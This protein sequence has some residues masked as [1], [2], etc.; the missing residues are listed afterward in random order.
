MGEGKFE[1]SSGIPALDD[2]L[3][4]L[5]KGD[6]VVWETD[7]LADY[8]H[9]L[10]PFCRN[11]VAEGKPLV[12]FRFAQH[13]H[14]LPADVSAEVVELSP[15][16]GFEQ[17]V[18]SILTEIEKHGP[19]AC[20]VFDCLS[21]LSVDWYSDRMLG[22][23]FM[24]TCPYL[25]D[26]DTLTY[27]LLRKSQHMPF[28]V[29]AIHN[30]AQVVVEVY[31]SEG[32]RY[33]LPIKVLERYSPTMYTLHSCADDAF[34]PVTKSVITAQILS[35]VPQTWLDF[36]IDR[37]DI[38]TETF[39]EAQAMNA[40]VY[41]N[42]RI[43]GRVDSLRQQLIRMI[44]TREQS[45][46]GLCDRYLDVP[47]LIDIGKRM[48]GTGLIGGKSVGMILARA[49]LRHE[50]PLRAR[51]L[52]THDSF[53]I[54]SDVFYTYII[55][56]DCWWDRRRLKTDALDFDRA[57]R[58]QEK[59]RGG[60]F[61]ADIIEQF[62]A[63]L[64]YFGQSPIIVRSSS[65]LED[66][67]GNAFSGKY[68]SVFCAN[69]GSPEQRL[70]RFI[71]AVQEVYASAM[72]RDALSYRSQRGLL[73][74][75][76][77]M[78]LLVQRVSGAFYGDTYFPQ[79][80]GVGYSFNPYVWSPTIDSAQGVLRLVFGLGTRAVDRCGDD[81][82][83]L[84]A[85][86]QPRLRPGHSADDIQRYSQ[87]NLDLLDLDDNAQSERSFRKI[88]ERVTDELPLDMFSTRDPSTEK[89]ARAMGLKSVFSRVLD[90]QKL[91]NDTPFVSDMRWILETIE[92]AY[93]HPVD[94]EFCLNFVDDEDYRINLLQCRP[95]QVS[96]EVRHVEKLSAVPAESVVLHTN[97]PIIG[98][99][100]VKQVDRII[101]VE[102][103]R[104]S[105]LVTADRWGCARLVGDL[106]NLTK[107]GENVMLIGPG[108]WGTS[109]PSLGV[110]VSFVEIKS[111]AI[112]CEVAAMHEGLRPD[113]SLGT[114]FF[115]DLVELEI[116]YMALDPLTPDVVLN[117]EMLRAAPNRLADLKP[118]LA[119]VWGETVRVVA[120]DDLREGSRG[121]IHVD[122]VA[123]QAT[124]F[125]S[126]A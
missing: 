81:Y 2:V 76:E 105:S 37:R 113:I 83:C 40:E 125:V 75:D 72:S 126:S 92:R 77:Q 69:Q 38:W 123:Q 115:N 44:I 16:D 95:F 68:D 88:A 70:T 28:A 73:E 20:Y 97:G 90:F 56:N 111:A 89:R 24:L 18:G 100:V 23:F 71:S 85:L 26:Y 74:Q 99:S 106:T 21:G 9:F 4:G 67:Y 59:I 51:G 124:L 47:A 10:L 6:N 103:E 53:Y 66:A 43:P 45:M 102:P 52:E 14:V 55:Q 30:T 64:N 82:T 41:R 117:V 11:A 27:F 121:R 22:N 91:L 110:P 87:H 35:A 109:M 31:K 104:Y 93:E 32:K 25:Y 112:L 29:D 50:D 98:Q 86:S 114:H 61:T 58:I 8:E 101:Y 15:Q 13:R 118:E 54:G 119:G 60:V 65:L 108:R 34:R 46:F 94:I 36:S 57:A 96:R 19:G 1:F 107:S 120:T 33:I 63:M 49:I 79:A 122:A 5:I 84:V 80:A 39:M 17:F 7:S 78:A 48:I 62:R 3:H 116:L 12:Y 42:Q